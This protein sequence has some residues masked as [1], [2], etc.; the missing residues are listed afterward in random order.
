MAEFVDIHQEFDQGNKFLLDTARITA[1][2]LPDDYR[3]IIKYDQQPLPDFDDNRLNI[4]FSTSREVHDIPNNFFNPK[5]HA[6]FQNYHWLNRFDEEYKNSITRP[7]PLGTFIDIKDVDIIP[8]PERKYDFTFIG[9]L[10]HTGTRAGFKIGLE[11]ML[12]NFPDKYNYR[13]EFTDGFGQGLP[14]S[15]FIDLLNNS[16]IV[17]CPYGAYSPETFRFFEILKMGAIPMVERLPHFWYYDKAP[18]VKTGWS[19]LDKYLSIALNTLNSPKIAREIFMQLAEYN[20]TMLNETWLAQQLAGM[21]FARDS[22]G[23]DEVKE[24][25]KQTR[26]AMK[27]WVQSP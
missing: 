7:L 24:E 25:L 22:I 8:M 13:I 19:K 27:K 17:L 5:V 16:K 12:E 15:E 2:C 21:I 6:I 3:V 26:K 20:M 11:Q 18:F 14:H 1:D 4:E 10:P 9:Q 23:I